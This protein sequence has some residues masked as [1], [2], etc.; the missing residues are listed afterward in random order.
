MWL[1]SSL[2]P[3]VNNTRGVWPADLF[4]V[5]TQNKSEFESKSRYNP[6]FGSDFCWVGDLENILV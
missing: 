5:W 2:L 1:P 3:D 4:W 6:R